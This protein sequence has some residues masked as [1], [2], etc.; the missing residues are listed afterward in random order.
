MTSGK[1]ED[2]V[3]GF[4]FQVSLME[5]SSSMGGAVTTIA[6]GNVIDNPIAG[7]NECSGLEM[8]LDV[9]EYQEGGNNGTVLKFA[10]RAK[11]STITLKKG[12]TT[13]TE[14]WDWLY[15]FV[16]GRGQRKDGVVTLLDSEHNTH[17]A[18]HFVRA[19]PIRYSAPALNAQ[20]NNVAIESLELVHEGLYQLSGARGLAAAVSGVASAASDLAKKIL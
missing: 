13:G 12:L 9:E 7:F 17:T 15:G 4:N 18:W 16:E 3:L 14:L 19:L 2:P 6:F 1:R 20:Q 8:S 5:S 10:S 11:W